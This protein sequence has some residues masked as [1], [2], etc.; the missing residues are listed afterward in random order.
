MTE[1]NIIHNNATTEHNNGYM[2][3]AVISIV[4]TLTEL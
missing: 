2:I 4:M 1:C 3:V